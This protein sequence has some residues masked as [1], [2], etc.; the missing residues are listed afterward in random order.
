MSPYES[1][2]MGDEKEMSRNES[3]MYKRKREKV[4]A[5][6]HVMGS[7]GRGRYSP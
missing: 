3:L 5:A 2:I 6:A 1:S 4:S 7:R